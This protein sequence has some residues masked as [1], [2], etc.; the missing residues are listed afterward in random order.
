MLM[1][2]LDIVE[3]GGDLL[4]IFVVLIVDQLLNSTN[5]T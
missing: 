1:L 3:K 2:E 4:L 5:N